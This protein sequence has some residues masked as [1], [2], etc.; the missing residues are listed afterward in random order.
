MQSHQPQTDW[1]PLWD[2]YG[3]RLLLFARHQAPDLVDAEDIVQEAFLRYWRLQTSDPGLPPALMF[4]FVRRIAVDQARQSAS[5]HARE[6]AVA[7]L[8]AADPTFFESPVEE[9]ER[10]D[11]IERGL[12]ALPAAQMEVMVLKI[13]GGLTFDEIGQV[14]ELSPNTAASRFRYGLSQLRDLLIPALR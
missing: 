14:L 4:T 8:T 6:L 7:E 9:R 13:W 11:L 2:Q 12:R 1:R 5:R 10:A 3:P